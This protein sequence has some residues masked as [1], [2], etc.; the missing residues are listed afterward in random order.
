MNV[1]RVI[2]IVALACLAGFLAVLGSF[3]TEPPLIVVL[4]LGV[5]MAGYDFW[6][7]LFGRKP[8]NR[9]NNQSG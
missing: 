7:E 6:L 9:N 3:V 8:E 1:D 4:V 5:L 2:G